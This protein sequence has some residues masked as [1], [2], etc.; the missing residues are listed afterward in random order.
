MKRVDADVAAGRADVWRVRHDPA[1]RESLDARV[2]RYLSAPV[3]LAS[4]LFV[5]VAVIQLNNTGGLA[6][7]WH[8]RFWRHGP[9]GLL[10]WGTWAFLVLEYLAKLALAPDKRAYL[11]RH[12]RGAVVAALPVF[13]V[14][15]LADVAIVAPLL[16]LLHGHGTQPHLAIL[17]KR[18][19]G[20]LLLVTAL[21]ILLAAVL[22][23]IC[24]N[25][26]RGAT[27]TTF[28][29]ALW[30]AAATV[31]TVANQLYPVTTGGE[32]VAFLLMVYA[33][34]VFAYLA[35]SMA[36]ALIGGDAQQ[37]AQQ[38]NQPN[39][40]GQTSQTGQPSIPPAGEAP[41]LNRA[42]AGGYVAL[43]QGELDTLRALLDRA[44]AARPPG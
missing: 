9:P 22:E 11:R 27:I 7:P 21:V 34:V 28:G 18:K 40:G 29:Q 15:R 10:F 32:I 43:S 31:T 44:Q 8:R 39:Q 2:H 36:S 4:L 41:G 25:G 3:A 20:R 38:P 19:L 16:G 33:V 23:Y 42:T 30:W 1:R 14:V 26:A 35:S 12:W 24:E 37:A 17:R 6:V 13:G 5:L